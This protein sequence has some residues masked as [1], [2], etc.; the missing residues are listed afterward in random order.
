MKMNHD[1]QEKLCDIYNG[2]DID[3]LDYMYE[4]LKDNENPKM[5]NLLNRI[6]SLN[7]DTKL[8]WGDK[9]FTYEE[10]EEYYEGK[11]KLLNYFGLKSIGGDAYI[12]E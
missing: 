6:R 7:I 2:S 4:F 9:D 12:D 1:Q 5:L 11:W 3:A 8:G 10:S